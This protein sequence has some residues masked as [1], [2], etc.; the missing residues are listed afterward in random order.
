[1]NSGVPHLIVVPIV[2]PLLVAA[3]LLL[4]GDKRRRFKSIVNGGATLGNLLVALEILRSVDAGGVPG[5]V[6]VYLA[7]NWQPHFG[8]V[9]V[10]DRLRP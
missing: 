7:A 9:L 8:I 10:A 1:M 2:L 3:L 5:A 4:I 6:G